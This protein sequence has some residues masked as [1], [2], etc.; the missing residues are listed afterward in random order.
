MGQDT[1][2]T[3]EA[4]AAGRAAED[5]PEP[6]ESI[7]AKLIP[8]LVPVLFSVLVA[9]AY[10]LLRGSYVRFYSQYGVSPED[11]GLGQLQLFSGL[12]RFCMGDRLPWFGPLKLVGLLAIFA[13]VW[14]MVVLYCRKAKWFKKP[15]TTSRALLAITIYFI[16]LLT[17]LILSSY[18]VLPNDREFASK[19]I[20]SSRSVYMHELAFLAIQADTA[21]VTWTDS[22]T[23]SPADFPP[24][25]REIA[26]LGHNNDVAIVFDASTGYTWKIPESKVL[27]KITRTAQRS[28]P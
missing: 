8:A 20:G 3:R 27:L 17:L 1:M 24:S 21:T 7:W 26:Y 6:D 10:G 14:V 23:T 25:D 15:V 18:V 2:D 16:V 9:M 12:L 28:G 22:V 19:R 5:R 4:L 13:F 11:V